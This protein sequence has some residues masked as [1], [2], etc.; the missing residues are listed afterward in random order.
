MDRRQ[1]TTRR[2]GNAGARWLRRQASAEKRSTREERISGDGS[3][4]TGRED[5]LVNAGQPV[6]DD[7]IFEKRVGFGASAAC[8]DERL[9]ERQQR[10]G[11]IEAVG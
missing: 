1:R 2:Q 10:I 5:G 7:G 4:V 3:G 8:D 6:V 11:S 9:G